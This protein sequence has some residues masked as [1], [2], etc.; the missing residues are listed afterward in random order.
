MMTRLL[1]IVVSL[2]CLNH[3]SVAQGPYAPAAGEPGTTA[4]AADSSVFI[5]W[6]KAAVIERGPKNIKKPADGLAT[7]GDAV[8]PTGKPGAN[9]IVS[10]GDGGMAT[11]TFDQPIADIPGYDFAIFENSFSNTFLELGFVEVS[12]DGVNYFRFDA[13]SL[14]DTATQVDAFGSIDPTNVN[15]LAGKYRG[16]YGTPF[17]LAELPGSAQLDK[18]N[19]TH[20]RI[21][22]VIGTIDSQLASRDV[23]G[24]PINDPW[25]TEFES[26]GFDLDAVGVLGQAT[27]I[28]N[29]NGVALSM[30][31]NPA[32]SHVTIQSESQL[33]MDV[34]ITDTMGKEWGQ[35]QFKGE[36][37]ID[38][39]SFPGGTYLVYLH[40]QI[41]Q[42]VQ[43]L[44]VSGS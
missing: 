30:Y 41:N 6:A 43:L 34:R 27:G 11:L 14:T 7:V 12:S 1:S 28:D 13:V 5:A 16:G 35:W 38:L 8:S 19:I 22:D 24:F 3:T 15:G 25:P 10:L 44:T 36:L 31:P 18:Q 37:R 29:T 21:I 17:D 4:I 33:P 2:F 23:N 32:Q 42:S 40:G 9:G 20:V 26:S 39:S